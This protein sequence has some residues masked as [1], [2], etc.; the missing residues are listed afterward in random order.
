MNEPQPAK[1]DIAW[2]SYPKS[3]QISISSSTFCAPDTAACR[4]FIASVFSEPAVYRLEINPSRGCATLLH[5][6]HCGGEEVLEGIANTL[7][8]GAKQAEAV[9]SHGLFLRRFAQRAVVRISRYAGQLSTCEIAHLL[10]GRVRFRHA[11]LRRRP[12]P[13]KRVCEVLSV[14]P[15]VISIEVH[16]STGCLVVLYNR[17]D[18][19]LASILALLEQCLSGMPAEAFAAE[20]PDAALLSKGA[21]LVTAAMSDTIAPPLVPLSA[22]MLLAMEG[23]IL[24]EASRKIAD[25]QLG[26]ETLE[27]ILILLAMK[28]GTFLPG[29]LMAFLLEL[30]PRLGAG[31]LRRQ[32]SLLRAAYGRLPNRAGALEMDGDETVPSELSQKAVLPHLVLSGLALLVRDSGAAQAVL[33]PDYRTGPAVAQRMSALRTINELAQGGIWIGREVALKNFL[34]A[35]VVVINGDWLGSIPGGSSVLSFPESKFV[36]ATGGQKSQAR[37]KAGLIGA[38]LY[39]AGVDTALARIA[40]VRCFRE[41]G[42]R[43]CYMGDRSADHDIFKEAD[44]AVALCGDEP[45]GQKRPAYDISCPD[46]K[47]VND[48]LRALGIHQRRIAVSSQAVIALNL[49]AAAGGLFTGSS[50]LASVLISNLGILIAYLNAGNKA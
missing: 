23:G 6:P 2:V 29:A 35:D 12:L 36:I 49:A 11:A 24:K 48:L 37:K 38:D 18:I 27:S 9:S 44:V 8:K 17:Q 26:P 10:P 5:N 22:A 40:V 13:A 4:R 46:V 47:S 1:N 15:G 42:F 43:V 45:V 31:A 16:S 33:R 3:G 19:S 32:E 7:K 21:F 30:W 14:L 25:K 50:P 39:L 41:Q 20:P 34:K 28:T